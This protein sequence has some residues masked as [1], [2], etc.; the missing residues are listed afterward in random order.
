[1]LHF[2][3]LVESCPPSSKLAALRGQEKTLGLRIKTTVIVLG[4]S[5]QG[6]QDESLHLS[7]STSVSS[8]PSRA[9]CPRLG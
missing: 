4:S 9:R 5:L 2:A 1:M 6:D 8:G 7:C 3:L